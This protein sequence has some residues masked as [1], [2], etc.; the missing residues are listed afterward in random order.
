MD[1]KI[2]SITAREILDSRGNPTVETTVILTSGYRGVAAAPSG[3]STGKYEAL[4]LRDRDTSRFGGMGVLHAV[5]NVNTEIQNKLRGMDALSQ[6]AIDKTL[7]DLDGTPNKSRLGANAILSVSVATAIA[8]A[9]AS[10]L[11]L[12]S[13]FRKIAGYAAV[14]ARI[15]APLFNLIEGGMHATGA[16]DF[17]EFHIIPATNKSYHT[18]MQIGVEIMRAVKDVLI[19]RNTSHAVGDEGGFAP[20]LITNAEVFDVFTE[21]T[22]NTPYKLGVDVFFGLDVAANHIYADGGYHIKDRAQAFNA[23]QFIDYFKKL[24]ETNPLIVLEDPLGEDDWDGWKLAMKEIGGDVL[25]VGDDLLV[26]SA[27]KLTRAIAEKACSAIL[28]KPNQIGTLSE[29]FAV[30]YLAKQHNIKTILSHRGG[31]TTDTYIADLAVALETDYVKFGAPAR[32]E[33]VAKYNRLL[34]IENELK[35]P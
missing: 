1:A 10:R 34:Q 13:Y 30:N 31:E 4:E 24:K 15:G 6:G 20:N 16:M 17:Q 3:V 29:F 11:P 18:A 27:E 12:Y 21:A 23:A 35:L 2:Y 25:I 19:Y 9:A 28:L 32:G 8:A 26:T 5:T 33:R 22:K 7:V 14:P